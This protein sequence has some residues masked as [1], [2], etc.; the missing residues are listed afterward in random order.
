MKILL[1]SPFGGVPGGISRWTSHI[2]NY[3]ETLQ[4]PF[5]EMD[6]LPMGRSSFVNINSSYLY[7]I[8]SA[9]CDYRIILKEF[10]TH[11]QKS[12]YD[13]LHLASSASISLLKDFY[14]LRQAKR[15]G[16]KTIIHFHFGRIPDLYKQQN[17]EWKLMIRVVKNADRIVV[18]DKTSY[19]TL[20][21]CGFKNVSILPN[22]V[23]PEVNKI[24]ES[25]K[26]INRESNT[27]LFTGHVVK[28]KGVFELVEACNKLSNVRL[29][30]VGHI[31]DDMRISLNEMARC[32]LEIMGEMPYEN[33]IKEM[34]K[35]DIFVLPTYTEGFPNVILESMAAGCAIVT[36]CVGAIPEMLG[37]GDNERY[38]LIVKPKD[39]IALKDAIEL[40]LTDAELKRE[41][42]SSV[43]QRVNERY[44][45]DR[46]WEKMHNLW[47]DL[48]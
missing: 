31:E 38:A 47:A 3:Y 22:P 46:V 34:L 16:I 13:V 39:E 37:N 21:S 8:V 7:R 20:L 24:V 11:L 44:S 12:Q 25:N 30:L 28:T 2:N 32:N 27:I 15:R 48:Y 36:T 29:K 42:R 6:I 19:D 14:M 9:L 1:A 5:C 26:D 35:C 40:L 45:I 33:V 10:R 23:A 4:N 18:L 43:S 17:W 41:F